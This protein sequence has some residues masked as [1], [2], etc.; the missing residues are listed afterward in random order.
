MEREVS[1]IERARPGTRIMEPNDLTDFDRLPLAIRHSL[2]RICT[3]FESEWQTGRPP[4]IEAH[5]ERLSG[6]GR[7]VL[8]GELLRL[9]LD[10]RKRLGETPD[11][12]GYLTRFGELSAVVCAVLGRNP[13]A[14][15]RESTT[16]LLTQ[17]RA[18]SERGGV[19]PPAVPGYVLEGELGR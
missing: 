18:R 15:A 10:Y 1:G 8:L 3:D 14:L 16:P 11:L 17:P 5:L 2:D 7:S 4:S 13:T 6:T 19:S 9:D 12:A